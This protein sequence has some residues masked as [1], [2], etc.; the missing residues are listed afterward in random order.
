MSTTTDAPGGLPAPERGAS[1]LKPIQ[2]IAYGGGDMANNL[3]FSLSISF[4]AVYYTDVALLAPATVGLIF[5]AMRFV[6]AFTD[7]I[8]GS[9]IDRTNTRMGK[10]RPYIMVFCVPLVLSAILAFSMPAGLRG[11]DGALIWAVVTYFLLGSVFYTLVN[12]PYG[13]LAAAMTDNSQDR[14]KL[15]LARTL[16]S[17][18]MQI[19]TAV[20][21]SPAMQ[22]F[23]G[24]PDGLQAALTRTIALLGAG[25]LVLYAFLVITS[26]ENVE[27][28]VAKVSLKES[29]RTLAANRALQ[30]LA[31]ISVV[32][33]AGLFCLTGILIYYARD[34]LG[35]ARYMIWFSPLMFGMIVVLGWSIPILSQRLGKPRVFQIA[36]LVGVVGGLLMGLLGR[37]ALAMAFVGVTLI[38]ASSSFVNTLMWNMEADAVEYGEWKTGIRNEGTTYAI[39]SFVRKMAQALGGWAG[40]WLIG[41]FGYVPGAAAQPDSAIT[42][43]SLAAGIVP[44]AFFLLSAILVQFYPLTDKRHAQIL[45]DLRSRKETGILPQATR[46][47]HE[48]HAA[49]DADGGARDPSAE[50]PGSEPGA[51]RGK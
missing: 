16:G 51:P 8:I 47:E 38:G 43:I 45:L 42:G 48:E 44:A 50:A 7:V 17:G 46:D 32:Y 30:A 14:S 24:D 15:A 3:A 12:I 22:Q 34:V 4:L 13:S 11:T 26:R 5:L 39:F 20:A 6:D 9:V 49:A 1:R 19:V 31:G 18:I 2:Y 10:F 40:L 23:V 41:V 28:R 33:L 35:D 27:R 36:A 21:I 37:D 25:A 29:F